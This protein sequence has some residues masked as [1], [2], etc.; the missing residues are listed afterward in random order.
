MRI[1]FFPPV[2]LWS[3]EV[4]KSAEAHKHGRK[5]GERWLIARLFKQGLSSSGSG[6]GAQCEQVSSNQP[7]AL[8]SK[9]S[10]KVLLLESVLRGST[11]ENAYN[12]STCCSSESAGARSH[13]VQELWFAHLCVSS[14][15]AK[16]STPL[17]PAALES[18]YSTQMLQVLSA[19]LCASRIFL[20]SFLYPLFLC[21]ISTY[22]SIQGFC[23]R[24]GFRLCA[25]GTMNIKPLGTLSRLARESLRYEAEPAGHD[26]PLWVKLP[27]ANCGLFVTSV[28]W[29]MGAVQRLWARGAAQWAGFCVTC[30]SVL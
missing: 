27:Y 13:Q 15:W 17:L 5:L 4:R 23:T 28:L 14:V 21:V 30:L 22:S 7:I 8:Y 26:S 2:P 1:F 24:M 20:H 10:E 18:C 11:P 3:K 25:E 12:K 19:V 6:H 16:D 29:G 9:T